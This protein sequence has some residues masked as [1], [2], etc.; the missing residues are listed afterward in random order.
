M[1]NIFLCLSLMV[2][3]WPAWSEEQPADLTQPDAGTETS[4]PVGGS[5]SEANSDASKSDTSSVVQAPI[6][7]APAEVEEVQ[8]VE[9]QI[10]EVLI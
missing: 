5:K 6:S 3:T 10:T 4:E 2:F 9:V 1:Q 8:E 7:P